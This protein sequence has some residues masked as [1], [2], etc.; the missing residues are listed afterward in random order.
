MSTIAF[1]L[2]IFSATLHAY[3]NLIAKKQAHNPS[4]FFLG[5]SFALLVL[6]APAI[7]AFTTWNDLWQALPYMMATGVGWE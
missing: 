2:V 5:L 4:V 3:W 1:I 7:F 6:I